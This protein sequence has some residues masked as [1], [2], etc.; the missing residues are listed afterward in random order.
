MQLWQR[1]EETLTELILTPRSISW[2]YLRI[3]LI[4]PF[5]KPMLSIYSKYRNALLP[6]PSRYGDNSRLHVV[7]NFLDLVAHAVLHGHKAAEV[8]SL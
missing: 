8:I 1:V 4:S 2:R 6:E 7:D 3:V 5:A